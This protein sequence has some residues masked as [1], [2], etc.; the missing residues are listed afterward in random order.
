[1]SGGEPSAEQD[2][3]EAERQVADVRDR[4]KA[5]IDSLILQQTVYR[6]ELQRQA[7]TG[8]PRAA[9]LKIYKNL[10]HNDR[11]IE[12]KQRLYANVQRETSQL[13]DTTTNTKVAA[14]MMR[15]VEAQRRLQKMDLGGEDVQD[16]LD[17]IDENRADTKELTDRLG[18]MGVEEDEFD[19]STFSAGHVVSALGMRTDHS[20]D[21]LLSEIGQLMNQGWQRPMAS[22]P[23]NTSETAH[24]HDGQYGGHDGQYGQP[25]EWYGERSADY[26]RTPGYSMP[27]VPGRTSINQITPEANR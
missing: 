6:A 22:R 5:E 24:T 18:A 2:M 10:K 1:M 27:D 16:V 8:A 21:L 7:N 20:D 23:H 9:M 25:S 14:A 26:R 13:Q 4:I 17:Y 19:E 15:S 11:Q 12:E 3:H